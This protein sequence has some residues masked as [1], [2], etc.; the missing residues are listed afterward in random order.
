M[1]ARLDHVSSVLLDRFQHG[2][3]LV[4]RPFGDVGEVAGTDA[5]D[6][7]AR[8]RQMVA[9]GLISRIGAVVAPNTVGASTLA[10]IAAAPDDIE[11]VAAVV[12]SEHGVNHNYERENAIN[13]W[14]VVAEADAAELQRTLDRIADRTGLPVRD[15]RLEK[16]YHLDLGFRLT[17]EA[18]PRTIP[19]NPD[20]AALLPDDARLLNIIAEG[21][22]LVER[23]YRPVGMRLGRSEEWVIER[24]SALIA[25]HV[26]RRFGVVVRHRNLG[27]RAN[28]MVVWDVPDPAVDAV[29]E[30]LAAE[31][32]VTLCY[33]RRRAADWPYNLYCMVHGAERA[34]TQAVVDRLQAL[35]GDA[36]R[37]HAVLFSTRCFKQSGRSFRMPEAAA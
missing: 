8:Y 33:R 29:G 18:M 37:S 11:R 5:A 30:R 1:I 21:L 35:P 34:A 6:A 4:V 15:L 12:S 24:V 2:F 19:A 3:P 16:P 36:A 23:P 32:G 31:A 28:A 27:M 14:F 7:I 25:A 10:A 9:E 13:L 20:L 22:P 17:G 26:I